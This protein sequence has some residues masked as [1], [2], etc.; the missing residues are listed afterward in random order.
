[1]IDVQQTVISQYA[2]SPT[3]MGLIERMNDAID[4]RADLD[5]IYDSIWNIE[6]AKGFGLDIWGRIVGVSRSLKIPSSDKFFGFAEA[7]P[8]VYP[9]GEG[10][11]YD[12]TVP[13]SEVV[14]LPDESF[15]KLILTKAMAN[16][17]L[18]NAPSI[19]KLLQNLFPGRGDCHVEDDGGMAM[20]YVFNFTLTP[21]ERAII[22]QS[23]VIPRPAGV[24]ALLKEI[25]L[26][27]A[28]LN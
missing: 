26:P 22:T 10:V 12:G 20:S 8:G 7:V 27:P 21:I 25:Y 17:T 2:N 19:N 14:L 13:E 23:G 28:V 3:I 18:M 11:F 1:M 15:R 6:T 16:I 4:P 5:A 9:F 24:S